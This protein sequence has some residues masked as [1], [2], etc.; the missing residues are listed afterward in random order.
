MEL[1]VSCSYLARRMLSSGLCTSDA[2]ETP[3][4]NPATGP[5]PGNSRRNLRRVCFIC[6]IPPFPETS[7]A[8]LRIRKFGKFTGCTRFPQLLEGLVNRTRLQRGKEGPRRRGTPAWSYGGTDGLE[9]GFPN[10]QAVPLR[11]G[12]I[13]DFPISMNHEQIEDVLE[14]EFPSGKAVVRHQQITEG[15]W[16]EF[17]LSVVDRGEISVVRWN[18]DLRIASIE[19]REGQN[20]YPT[21]LPPWWTYPLIVL[22]PILGFLIPWGTVRAFRPD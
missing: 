4:R 21:P 19:T 11:D 22:F 2:N 18:A 15:P 20:L 17:P 10:S 8:A 6:R 13:R 14:K 5:A 16:E 7:S 1:W 3:K 12:L 9:F